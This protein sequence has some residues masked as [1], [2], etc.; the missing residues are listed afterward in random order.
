MKVF[1][2]SQEFNFPKHEGRDL[3]F[4]KG[5]FL[6]IEGEVEDGVFFISSG[7]VRIIK[8]KWVLWTANSQELIGISSFFSEGSKYSFSAKASDDCK[9]VKISHDEF[10]MMLEENQIFGK[11]IIEMMCNRIKYTNN[12]LRSVMTNTSRFRLI[13]EIINKSRETKNQ[14]IFYSLEELS[15]L[16]GISKRLVR[17]M[18]A[19]LEKKTLLSR[20]KNAIIINDLKG[21]EIIAMKE[22][23]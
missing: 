20:S 1:S 11:T 19:E 14:T 13:N 10:Q 5:E 18:L 4:K 3:Q 21:L 8:K 15:E 17:S 22:N 12:R 6:F 2:Q 9:I 23:L 7:A 16:V